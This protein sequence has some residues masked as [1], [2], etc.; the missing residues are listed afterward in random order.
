MRAFEETSG[1]MSA[2]GEYVNRSTESVRDG[3]GNVI[4][5]GVDYAV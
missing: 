1:E 5:D 3:E 2:T 4:T